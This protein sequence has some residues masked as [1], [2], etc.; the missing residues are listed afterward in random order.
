M[1]KMMIMWFIS[2]DK[3]KYRIYITSCV[4]YLT[5]DQGEKVIERW[6]VI[7]KES[8]L[9]GGSSMKRNYVNSF[10]LPKKPKTHKKTFKKKIDNWITYRSANDCI[11]SLNREYID[12]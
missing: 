3:A 7:D 8:I 5:T 6:Y 9:R 10:L 4:V 1:E 2:S 11:F 12:R